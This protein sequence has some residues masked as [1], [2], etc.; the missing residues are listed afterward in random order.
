MN[1]RSLSFTTLISALLLGLSLA[2]TTVNAARDVSSLTLT[3][4]RVS[5][6]GTSNIHPYTAAS[7]DVRLMRAKVANG[8]VV[9]GWTDIL[10]PGAIE[11]FEIAIPAATLSSP[12]EGI[13]K[14]MHKA[15]KVTEH[16][17]ITFRLAR[18]EAMTAPGAYQAIGT[19][20]IAGVAR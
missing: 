18:L 11:A 20:E 15:L 19:L 17:D 7:A 1:S 10:K 14:T 3:S 4:G 12:K 9:E 16:P 13:D 5:I 6:S 8:V 2:A